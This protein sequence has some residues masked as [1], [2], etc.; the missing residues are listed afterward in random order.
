MLGT[1]E[2]NEK[3]TPLTLICEEEIHITT[4]KL[5]VGKKKLWELVKLMRNSHNNFNL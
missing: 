2:T 5:I 4:C 1:S 3:L